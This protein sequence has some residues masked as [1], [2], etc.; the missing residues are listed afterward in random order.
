MSDGDL[1]YALLS[2]PYA[3]LFD[4]TGATTPQAAYRYASRL[5]CLTPPTLVDC[6]LAGHECSLLA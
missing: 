5:A 4:I 1:I 6:L 2:T 3:P